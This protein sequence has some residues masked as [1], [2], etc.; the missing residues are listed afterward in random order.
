MLL[1]RGL[2]LQVDIFEE[3]G[4]KN[5]NDRFQ[6]RMDRAQVSLKQGDLVSAHFLVQRVLRREPKNPTALTI[7]AEVSQRSGKYFDSVDLVNRI[8]ELNPAT[9]DS[10]LQRQ[11]GN[12]CFAIEMFFKA[13]QC[14]GWV[15]AAGQADVLSLYRLGVTLRRIGD[16]DQAEQVLV[17]CMKLR[18]EVE[19]PYLQLG[20]IFKARGDVEQAA[21]YYTQSISRSTA[22]RGTGYWCLADLKTYRFSDAEIDSMK[23]ELVQTQE[24]LPQ[25]SAL[26]FALGKAA[27]N[28]HDYADAVVNY[29]KG[30]DIQAR[31]KPFR[32]E[33]F[34]Q[35]VADLQELD[36]GKVQSSGQRACCPIFIVGLPR[37]GTTLIEQILSAHSRVQATDELPFLERIALRFELNGGYAQRLTAMS[38]GERQ[39]LGREYMNDA[40]AYIRQECDYFIDKFPGNF[41]H[42]GLIKRLFP[43]SI[44]IDVRRDPRDTAISAWRQLFNVGNEFSST[45]DNIFS[46]YQSYL[47]LLDHWRTIYPEQIKVLNYEQL[48]TAPTEEIQGLLEFCGLE[49]EAGCFEFYK[50]ERN[51]TTPSVSQVKQPMYTSSIR[52]WQH[53]AEFLPSEMAKLGSLIKAT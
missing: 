52:Q 35:L 33:H 51:V 22:E 24:N 25:L 2:I 42:V 47:A 37:T 26:Y 40:K 45:F 14:Y 3:F 41:L 16:L 7:C 36:A 10:A 46:Y 9:F 13:S 48:V 31:I 29:R 34:N 43:E 32:L 18:P 1:S 39:A 20:H 5:M 6:S 27:E 19:A 12:I 8:F 38:E 28:K 44:V 50:H 21:R 4:E 53:Y 15:K 30:N 23:Q 11:L 17:E 49:T